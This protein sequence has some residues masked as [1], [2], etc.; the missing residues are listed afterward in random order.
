MKPVWL[1]FHNCIVH[2]IMGVVELVTW[3]KWMPLFLIDFHDWSARKA[4]IE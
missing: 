4:G 1:F 3:D 2:P